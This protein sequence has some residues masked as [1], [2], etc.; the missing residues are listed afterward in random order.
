M[1]EPKCQPPLTKRVA[2][3]WHYEQNVTSFGTRVN[4]IGL[5]PVSRPVEQPLL[6]FKTVKKG[7]KYGGTRISE[8]FLKPPQ[9]TWASI[10]NLAQTS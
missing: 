2:P 5:Q 4:K 9:Q 1:A 3:R 7:E 6:G 8:Q 10:S